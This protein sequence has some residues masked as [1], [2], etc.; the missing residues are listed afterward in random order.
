MQGIKTEARPTRY[1]LTQLTHKE[2]PFERWRGKC[3][4][5]S[6]YRGND[7][8]Y[9]RA[10]KIGAV[11]VTIFMPFIALS[12]AAAGPGDAARAASSSRTGRSRPGPGWPPAE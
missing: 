1:W 2:N 5:R 11:L 8:P 10:A 3:T 9:P 4:A 12:A 6:W 7:A